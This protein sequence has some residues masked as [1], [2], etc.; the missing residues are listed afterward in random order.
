M[1]KKMLSLLLAMVLLLGVLAGCGGNTDDT[2]APKNDTTAPTETTEATEPPYT[3][4][5]MSGVKIT[6]YLAAASD[7]DPE[8][9]Y[10]NTVV[11]NK[12]GLDLEII[13]L[14][15]FESNMKTMLAEQKPPEL[16]YITN[17]THT[18]WVG[19]ALD[20]AFINFMD[21]MDK[22]PNVKAYLEDPAHAADV[23]KFTYSETELY[24]LPI[25]KTGDTTARA[26][27]YRKDIFEKNNI[28]I[29]TNQ[30]EF[31]ATLRKLKE[32]YP[33][34]M[35]FVMRS[36]NGGNI[37]GA[38]ALGHL[39]GASHVNRG[40]YG[41][42]FVLDADGEYSM[43]QTGQ[44]YKEIAEFIVEMT[45]EGLMHASSMTIDTAGWQEALASDTSFITYDK[46]DRIPQLTKQGKA[47]NEEYQI[48]AFA[49]F[50][51]GTYAKESDVV[52]TSFAAETSSFGYMVG[53]TDNID[54]VIT[55]LDWLYSEE[56]QFMTNWGVEGES[57]EVEADG[58]L[59]YIDSFLEEKGG[60][61]ACGFGVAGVTSHTFFDN[62][63]DTC[64]EEMAKGLAMAQEFI[65]KTPRQYA[66]VYNEEEQYTW[67]LYA[68]TLYTTAQGEWS[69]YALGQKDFAE[70]DSFL[71]LLK[72]SYY[73][74]E[75]KAIHD[76][77]LARLL[78]E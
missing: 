31:V 30:E 2:T 37:Q 48:A 62:F 57:Y 64:D 34:S 56:G 39:F 69:K 53:E 66:L 20:G 28:E 32:I 18:N 15:E 7:Y 78:G 44:A 41:T 33:D 68:E 76:S 72:D 11:E 19:Y 51:F 54:N 36:L 55:Y 23:E 45:K 75:V 71:Q 46:I 61:V 3:T 40:L 63:L 14:D 67:D 59:S 10:V 6:Q 52:S 17:Y 8:G 27:L 73:Y 22:M 9:C 25:G 5:D 12:L 21:Y 50:N 26:F 35:P 4:P 49:P 1:L 60:K 24:A 16:A 65:G 42:F 77:A 70:W 58:S 43:V 38:Q 74:D 13:E 29:P 47:L